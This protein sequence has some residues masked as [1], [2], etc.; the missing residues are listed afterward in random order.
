MS[1]D[2]ELRMAEVLEH[3][4]ADLRA[5]SPPDRRRLLAEHADLAEELDGALE[6]L[7]FVERGAAGA[8][9]AGP[10]PSAPEVRELGDFRILKEIGRGG[11]GVVYEAEQ[12]SLG[13]RVA[14]KVLPFAAVLDSTQLQRFKNEAQAAAHLHH[15]NIVPVYSIGCER[16]VHYYAMPFIEGQTVAALVRDLRALRTGPPAPPSSG[17]AIRAITKGQTTGSPAYCRSVAE[18]GVQATLALDHAHQQGVIHRDIK[19]ANL[20]MD[21]SGSVW[22]TDFGLASFR[23]AAGPGLTLTG[24]LLGTVRY[25]SPEQAL[26]KRVPVDHRTDVYSLGL[27]LYELLTLEPAFPGD[28]PQQILQ[29]I[30]FREP[31]PPSRLNRA[32][33]PELETI[34]IKATAKD[35]EARYAT[36][37]DMAEDLRR[38]LADKPIL[39]RRPSLLDRGSKWA[40]RHR[41]LVG[42]AAVALVISVVA[43]LVGNIR[44]ARAL[45]RSEASLATAREAVDLFLAEA[46]VGDPFP[47]EPLPRGGRERLIQ[48]AL[49]FYEDRRDDWN[50]AASHQVRGRLLL[51]LHRNEESLAAYDRALE[52]DPKL[53]PA[54]G[55]R[56]VALRRLG[57]FEESVPAFDRA[58][59][60]DPTYAKA[61]LNRGAALRGLGRLEESLAAFDRALELDPTLAEADVSRGVTLHDLGRL[62]ESL[63]AFDR[64][65][66]LDPKDTKAHYNRGTSLLG[67]PNE[68]LAAFDRALELDPEDAKTHCN[69]GIALH[70]LGRLEESLAA[71]D[72]AVELDPEDAKTHYNRGNALHALGRHVESLAAFDRALDLDPPYVAAHHSRGA[73]LHALDRLEEALAA[74][75]RAL[76]LDPKHANAHLNRGVT[77]HALGRLEE[78][79]AAADRALEL[80]PK[81][82]RAP[83]NRGA[84]LGAL[85]RFDEAL[86]ACDRALELDPSLAGAHCNRGNALRGLGRFEE[87]LAAC[88]R[89]LELDRS[90]AGAHC[91]RG[92]ALAGLGRFGEALAAYD[93]ALE[94]DPGLALAHRNR[95]IVLSRL[96]ELAWRLATAADP[97]GRDPARAVALAR[98]AVD[99]APNE[100]A[101]WNTL[102]VA[103][104]RS[105]DWTAAIAALDRS[106]QLTSGGDPWDWFFLGMACWHLGEKDEA[107]R[108]YEKAVVRMEAQGDDAGIEV[109]GDDVPV[110]GSSTWE[111][112][113][114][115]ELQRV[116][117]EAA[118]LLGVAL[119]AT[120]K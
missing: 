98:T 34:L 120:V 61:H 78:A 57:R 49:A 2:R 65:L 25:M 44:T 56:G 30:A 3:C 113:A 12:L 69:R 55:G 21:V 51:A 14:L 18:L 53:A 8:S 81:D 106:V 83:S 11:M 101:F 64:A 82:A 68:A 22:I 24:D 100:G 23:S 37:L 16:G 84:A 104:Y 42:S 80:D 6:A 74:F 19:P 91:N 114:E 79:L 39:A 20:I 63:A 96:N 52:L 27:T 9:R 54:H 71:F 86:A 29:E 43:L 89:A 48:R 41:A 47:D 119:P 87:A 94:L 97:A 107:R 95:G 72:R 7:G 77:L 26:A 85:G 1:P 28:N 17:A 13:R 31:R 40:R 58:L 35:P 73:A 117:A 103:H 90:L 102:G 4:L 99:R 111:G 59:R 108:W 60:L 62:E 45:R 66:E 5:G 36:A 70:V 93:R 88:D 112:A 105:G 38:F 15:T 76:E 110:S 67:R 109:S 33:P 32:V 50:D 75:D 116:R 115:E 118:A 10:E 46:G 92:N